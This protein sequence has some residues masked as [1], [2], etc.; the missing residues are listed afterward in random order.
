[1]EKRI[2][3]LILARGGSKR[4]PRKNIKL[5]GHKPLMAYTIKTALD[6]N[7][8]TDVIV[9]TED[10]EI[11]EIAKKFGA[12]VPFLRDEYYAGDKITDFQVCKHVTEELSKVGRNYDYIF[13]LRPTQPFRIIEDMKKALDLIKSGRFTSVRSVSKVR[14]YPQWMKIIKDD[15]LHSF[16]GL[17]TP[18]ERI[19]SQDLPVVYI[20]NGVCDIVDVKNL[21]DKEESLYGNKLGALI[22]EQDR[23]IDLDD[24]YDW[25]LAEMYLERLK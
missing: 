18:D 19:R 16:L 6:S 20:L 24:E 17:T 7:V 10:K 22:I 21:F 13:I 3:G 15:Q 9:S 11:A 4:I 14:Q 23:A 2:L 5:L 12:E 25:R 8:C 1:M